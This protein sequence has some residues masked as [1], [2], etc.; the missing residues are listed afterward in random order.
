[1]L[2][3]KACST[4][5]FYFYMGP[6]NGTRV[7]I[8]ARVAEPLHFVVVVC[9]CECVYIHPSIHTIH[10]CRSEN[11]IQ[12]FWVCRSSGS[13]G[14][15]W[16]V[17]VDGSRLCLYFTGRVSNL[18]QSSCLGLRKVPGVRGRR[19]LARSVSTFRFCRWP[20]GTLHRSWVLGGKCTGDV[21][22]WMTSTHTLE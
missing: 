4:K 18:L 8:L 10:V 6:G 15:N 19:Y 11:N 20:G 21:G 22:V 13:Q 5:A 14:S 7:L 9:A 3:I 17:R 1:M 2:G 16:V 12:V